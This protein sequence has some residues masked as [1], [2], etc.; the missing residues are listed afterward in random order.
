MEWAIDEAR[1][2]AR[3]SL[4]EAQREVTTL[5]RA[6]GS[7]ALRHVLSCDRRA[8]ACVLERAMHMWRSMPL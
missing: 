7:A 1:A 3:D 4:V 2:A 6:L 5:T 8:D